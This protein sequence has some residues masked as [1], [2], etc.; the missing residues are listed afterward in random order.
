MHVH[1]AK[2]DAIDAIQ[3]LPDSAPLDEIVYRLY[4]LNKVQQGLNDID[5]GRV[6]SGEQIA[7]EIEQW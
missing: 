1:T 6:V 7:Q 2:Q 3:R 5:A 4:L